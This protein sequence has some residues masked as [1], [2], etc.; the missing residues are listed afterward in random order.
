MSAVRAADLVSLV[1]PR[2]TLMVLITTAG[3]LWLAPRSAAHGGGL[4]RGLLVLLGTALIV[5]GANTLNMYIERDIDGRMKRTRDRPLPAGRMDPAVALWF[6][7][8][9]GALAVPL[10]V[11]GVNLLTGM[12]GLL[13]FLMYVAVYTPLKQYSPLALVVGAV[14]GAMP[15][16]MG[17]TAATGHLDLPGLVL[18]GILFLWQLPH[19]LAITLFRAEEMSRAGYKVTVAQRGPLAAKLRIILY[20]AALVPVSLLLV[21]LHVAGPLYLA[22]AA[23]LGAVFFA[24][25]LYG[26]KRGAGER[27][28]RS[29]FGVSLLYLTMLFGILALGRLLGGAA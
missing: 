25:G 21:P 10:L 2:I 26:L 16:L 29:L 20:V 5:G 19:F 12:L 15:P 1:K 11:F 14:P 9:L 6:G 22:G 23:V 24:W 3:G 17:W 27:W 28:A 4:Q 18:F 8:A 7:V 13:S